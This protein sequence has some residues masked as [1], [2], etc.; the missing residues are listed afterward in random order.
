MTLFLEV[1]RVLMDG[2]WCD[3]IIETR[4]LPA[5]NTPNKPL[6]KDEELSDCVYVYFLGFCLNSS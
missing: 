5:L 3:L 6:I 1:K 4:K 2:P